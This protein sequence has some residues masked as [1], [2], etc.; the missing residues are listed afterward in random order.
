M[1]LEYRYLADEDKMK[2][3]VEELRNMV[4]NKVPSF[5]FD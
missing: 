1:P 3:K 2:T 4:I 5:D